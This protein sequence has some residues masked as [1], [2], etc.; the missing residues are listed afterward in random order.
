[1]TENRDGRKRIT[2]TIIGLMLLL[3]FLLGGCAKDADPE[4]DAAEQPVNEQPVVKEQAEGP[5]LFRLPGGEY[6]RTS[7][8]L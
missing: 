7:G 3:S 4:G 2:C 6:H 5:W 1:M 8:L